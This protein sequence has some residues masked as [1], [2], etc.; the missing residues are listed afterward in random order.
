MELFNSFWTN[1]YQ[2]STLWCPVL[3]CCVLMN[4]LLSPSSFGTAAF[5]I[6]CYL[7]RIIEQMLLKIRCI[8][9]AVIWRHLRSSKQHWLQLGWLKIQPSGIDTIPKVNCAQ[10]HWGIFVLRLNDTWKVI[11]AESM[12]SLKDKAAGK[13][14]PSIWNS[15]GITL[16]GSCKYC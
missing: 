13:M 3:K 5:T 11:K 4:F 15:G 16:T 1:C 6:D 8:I 7:F 14:S 2:T 10:R 12:G 9:K